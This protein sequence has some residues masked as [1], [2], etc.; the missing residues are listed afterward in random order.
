LVEK[1][2]FLSCGTVFYY[3]KVENDGYAIVWKVRR[4]YDD[5][6]GRIR[7]VKGTGEIL[8]DCVSRHRQYLINK[9]VRYQSQKN[10]VFCPS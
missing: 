10:G 3:S 9:Q 7:L 8:E 5:D 6:T 4:V 2:N 1:S